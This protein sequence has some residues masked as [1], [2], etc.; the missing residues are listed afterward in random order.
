MSAVVPAVLCVGAVL[1]W[2]QT[3]RAPENVPIRFFA[4][5]ITLLA[6]ASVLRNAPGGSLIP[7]LP[8]NLL[9]IA[10]AF[11]QVCFFVSVQLG[12]PGIRRIR[13]ELL[14]ALLAAAAAV[15]AY[16]AAPAAIRNVINDNA[17]FGDRTVAFLF[18]FPITA[19]LVYA[20]G[21][22]AYRIRRILPIVTRRVLRVSLV[23]IAA[24]ACLQVLGGL[25]QGGSALLRYTGG[26]ATV[27][28]DLRPV[29]GT[30]V[31]I[32]FFALVVGA[33]VPLVDGV[34]REVPRIRAQRRAART[35]EPLWRELHTEFPELSLKLRSPGP[36]RALYRRVVE[37]RDGLVLLSPYFGSAVARDAA[38]RGRRA[39]ESDDEVAVA[40][41]AALVRDALRAR[42]SGH[43]PPAEV[44]RLEQQT[45][46]DGGAGDWRDD[47][48]TLVRLARRF[49]E[50]AVPV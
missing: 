9:N 45:V 28:V 41:Q 49:E 48:D 12:R 38:E 25:I 37:I 10:N 5:S 17:R 8:N 39:G 23:I 40:V 2:I 30:L 35:L 18:S 36:G 15:A 34:I 43:G 3:Y 1:L 27:P 46:P 44:V 33:I 42:R 19:Y 47:A 29:V 6:A 22:I 16:L 11:V 7:V 24:G 13:W 20:A 31:V 50:S 14:V 26:L 21:S 4:V 32:G